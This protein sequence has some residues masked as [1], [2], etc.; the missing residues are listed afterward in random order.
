MEEKKLNPLEMVAREIAPHSNILTDEPHVR[1][2]ILGLLSH[3]HER[4]TLQ[5][6]TDADSPEAVRCTEEYLVAVEIV[7][8]FGTQLIAFEDIELTQGVAN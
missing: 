5:L 4:A 7:N 3:L 1:R 2:R 8:Y 6:E